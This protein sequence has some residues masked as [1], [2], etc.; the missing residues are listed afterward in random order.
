MKLARKKLWTIILAS[1]FTFVASVSCVT[2]TIAWF[3]FQNTATVTAQSFT[4]TAQSAAVEDVNVIMFDYAMTTVGSQEMVD[5]IM[6]ERGKVNN[7]DFDATREQFG[8]LDDDTWVSVQIMNRYDPVDLLIS[9]NSLIDLNCNVVYQITLTSNL[10]NATM[11]LDALH[12]T[13]ATKD[14]EQDIFLT[15]C[16]DFDVF[17]A[18][19]LDDSNPLFTDGENTN[20]YYP[21]YKDKQTQVLTPT[22]IAN[23]KLYYQASYLASLRATH[24]HFYGSNTTPDY[25]RLT[26]SANVT[27]TNGQLVVYVNVNFAPSQLTRYQNNIYGGDIN[28]ICDFAFQFMFA[29]RS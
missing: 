10:D 29:S 20:I 13:G 27:F 5:Y 2:G 17:Y 6:P 8:Y 28:A 14:R 25:I 26:D 18:S 22:E 3:T 23:E 11:T 15:S 7:Y 21:D 16:V 9:G 4:V 24:P 19:D 1:A 12:L